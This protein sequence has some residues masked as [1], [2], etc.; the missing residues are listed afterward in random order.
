ML[1]Q[2][3]VQIHYSIRVWFDSLSDKVAWSTPNS[4]ETPSLPLLLSSLLTLHRIL[5]V[6]PIVIIITRA[7]A[8]T[9]PSTTSIVPIHNASAVTAN[10]TV[11][12]VAVPIACPVSGAW[13][14]AKDASSSAALEA[15]AAVIVGITLTPLLTGLDGTMEWLHSDR[16]RRS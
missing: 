15:A 8:R 14:R 13:T 1:W 2:A 12:T 4:P 6:E 16:L 5:V 7:E 11:G 9:T 3:V 10:P